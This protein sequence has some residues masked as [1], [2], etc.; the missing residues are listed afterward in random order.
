MRMLYT[1][2]LQRCHCSFVKVPEQLLVQDIFE[3]VEFMSGE[4]AYTKA[5]RQLGR[6]ACEID[7]KN[8]RAYNMDSPAGFA[9][10]PQNI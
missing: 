8:G 5:H 3:V 6:D 2:M 9:P 10:G 7:V 4:A 1:I